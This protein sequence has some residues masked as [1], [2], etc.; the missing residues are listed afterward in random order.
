ML[1]MLMMMM[2]MMMMALATE[3]KTRWMSSKA[4]LAWQRSGWDRS[5]A[6]RDQIVDSGSWGHSVAFG[7]AS[8]FR[9]VGLRAGNLA[10]WVWVQG[11]G[12]FWVWGVVYRILAL[13]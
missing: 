11:A 7:W 8:G 13:S 2:M 9:V 3:N 12:L 10:F 6:C 5:P 4:I 1:M